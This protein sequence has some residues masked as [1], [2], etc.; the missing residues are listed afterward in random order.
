MAPSVRLASWMV[1]KGVRV[2]GL[3]AGVTVV[4]QVLRPL[5]PEFN[6]KNVSVVLDLSRVQFSELKNVE[7]PE[8]GGPG[9]RRARL[10]GLD[11]SLDV[12]FEK[13]TYRFARSD[14]S[15]RRYLPAEEIRLVWEE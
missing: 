9:V 13:G 6:D 10:S 4:M 5:V 3:P 1:E 8:G 2:E 12:A 14:V 7:A 11:Y 15:E